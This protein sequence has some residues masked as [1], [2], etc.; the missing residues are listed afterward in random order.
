MEKQTNKKITRVMRPARSQF[1]KLYP[2]MMALKWCD[3]IKYESAFSEW[4]AIETA[5]RR[6]V[7][8]V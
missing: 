6:E 5:K 4:K 7:C 8:K 2:T 1:D 3:R